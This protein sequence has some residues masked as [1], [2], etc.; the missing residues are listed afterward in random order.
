V[1]PTRRHQ[2]LE[3]L[4]VV[5]TV[6]LL[7]GLEPAVRDLLEETEQ[8]LLR[9]LVEV[10]AVMVAADLAALVELVGLVSLAT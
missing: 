1:A 5:V 4:E 10:L 2:K 8:T 6:T 7:E 3:V 9:G